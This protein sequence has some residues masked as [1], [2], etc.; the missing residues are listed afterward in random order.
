M[1]PIEQLLAVIVPVGVLLLIL[2][3]VVFGGWR[4]AELS[5]EESVYRDLAVDHP[6]FRPSAILLGADCRSALSS[7][8]GAERLAA[9]IS[10]GDRAVTRVLERGGVRAARLRQTPKGLMLEA[11]LRDWSFPR[12]RLKTAPGADA[13]RWLE[14]LRRLI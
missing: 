10:V 12:F 5:D 6:E 3:S 13:E 1:I 14:A 7:E 4:S 2:I 11:D 8:E 9:A